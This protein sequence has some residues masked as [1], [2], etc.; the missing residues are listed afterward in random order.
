MGDQSGS[1]RFLSL[2]ESA[3]RAYESKTG[4]ALAEHPLAVRLQSCRSA[5]SITAVLQC[6]VHAFSEFGGYRRIMRSVTSI[7]SI[8]I[9]LS[10]TG[11]FSDALGLV[12][13][14]GLM[15]C[16]TSLMFL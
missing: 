9:A 1:A 14:K 2:F 8:L 4:I 11:P 7:V 16:S 5:E 6:Q 10:T 15:A 12:R 3:L 13:H